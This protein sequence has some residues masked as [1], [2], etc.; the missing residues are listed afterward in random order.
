V[1]GLEAKLEQ[2]EA[3]G[4]EVEA[5]RQ[6][7][8]SLQAKLEQ[9]EAAAAGPDRA[10]P[11]AFSQTLSGCVDAAVSGGVANYAPL[12][13]DAY[14]STYPEIAADLEAESPPGSGLRPKEGLVA[15]ALLPALDAHT[16]ALRLCTAIHADK[17]SGDMLPLH[18]FLEGR[19]KRLLDKVAEWGIG[20]TSAPISSSS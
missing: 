14:R 9:A 2:A 1:K 20:S 5:L 10:A 19:L 3:V 11:Q 13:T 17:C 8:E 18:A 15:R 16:R 7:V 12:F 6:Q 4:A